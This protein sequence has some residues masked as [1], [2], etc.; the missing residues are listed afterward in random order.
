MTTLAVIGAQYGSE[1]KGVIVHHLANDFQVH[2]RVGGPQAG[3]SFMHDN[4]LYKMRAIPCGWT[5]LGATLVIGRGAIIDPDVLNEELAM[6]EQIDPLI[7]DRLFIDAGAWCVT[8]ADRV[9]AKI[10]KVTARYGSTGEGVGQARIRRLERDLTND[11]RFGTVAPSYGLKRLIHDDT[12][13]M[14]NWLR[15]SRSV[16]LEGTQGAGLSLIHG[17]WPY[18]TNHDTNAAQ[19]AADC[20]LPPSA[21]D[22]VLLVMRTYPIRVAGNSGPL[23]REIDWEILSLRLG[24]EVREFTTVTNRQ[25]RIGEWEDGVIRLARMVNGAQHAALTFADYL[26]PEVE[27]LTTLSP[28]VEAFIRNV[29]ERHFLRIGLVGTGGPNFTVVDR[30]TK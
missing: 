2:V 18:T 22:D 29:E 30:R 21:I 25:R 12:A 27:G 6:I 28:M 20:G 14:L 19:L 4:V 1:G 26:D 7:W 24:K 5:N 3:H 9:T 15:G 16:L 8:R 13:S 11:M 17:P 10:G 23:Q